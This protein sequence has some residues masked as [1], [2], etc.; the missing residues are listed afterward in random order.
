MLTKLI[1][2]AIQREIR[3]AMDANNARLRARLDEAVAE[4]AFA[5]MEFRRSQ[6]ECQ[7]L[8]TRVQDL[9]AEKVALLAELAAYV[10]QPTEAAS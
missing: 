5:H 4:S 10:E 3:R 6:A 8:R 2:R 1:E 9:E 7:Q